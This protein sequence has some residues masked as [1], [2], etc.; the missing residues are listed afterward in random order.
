MNA[1]HEKKW[2]FK[3][4]KIQACAGEEDFYVWSDDF[5][6]WVE[7]ERKQMSL[8]VASWTKKNL[9]KTIEWVESLAEETNEKITGRVI[10]CDDRNVLVAPD[11]NSKKLLTQFRWPDVEKVHCDYWY[12]S[13]YMRDNCVNTTLRVLD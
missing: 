11:E 4:I 5:L 6:E 13:P 7:L 9:G 3:R 12:G 8:E 2:Y 1:E 10:G